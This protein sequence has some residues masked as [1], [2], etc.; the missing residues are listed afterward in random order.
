MLVLSRYLLD[1]LFKHVF[2]F[3]AN[4]LRGHCIQVIMPLKSSEAPLLPQ[5]LPHPGT[6]EADGPLSLTAGQTEL[7]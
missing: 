1:I 3:L 4:F 2:I 5:T 7:K 6:A